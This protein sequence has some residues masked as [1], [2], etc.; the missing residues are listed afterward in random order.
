MEKQLQTGGAARAQTQWCEEGDLGEVARDW[1][2]GAP[3]G[4]RTWAGA[5]PSEAWPEML[6]LGSRNILRWVL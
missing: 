2:G 1:D 5:R 3:G 4:G 6:D